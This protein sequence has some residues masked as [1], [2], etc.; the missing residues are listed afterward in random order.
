MVNTNRLAKPRSI[1]KRGQ[2]RDIYSDENGEIFGDSSVIERDNAV[3]RVNDSDLAARQTLRYY[4]DSEWFDEECDTGFGVRLNR[5]RESRG[6][7]IPPLRCNACNKAF[8]KV[9]K[10]SPEKPDFAYINQEVF[11]NIP[12]DR[13]VCGNCK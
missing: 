7:Y 9:I 1:N 12:L 5:K 3:E 4:F 6:S 10:N 11:A 8:Q 2:R 13:G